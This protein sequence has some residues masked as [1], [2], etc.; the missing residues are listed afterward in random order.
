MKTLSEFL[1]V[2][3]GVEFKI[4]GHPNEIFVIQ[5]NKLWGIDGKY[6]CLL[7]NNPL[8]GIVGKKIIIISQPILTDDERE[9]LKA[10]IDLFKNKKGIYVVKDKEKIYIRNYENDMNE[11]LLC[12]YAPLYL[13]FEKLSENYKYYLKDL[14]LEE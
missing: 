4:E 9:F 10:I 11:L 1:E 13:R 14:G 2:E 3:E 12:V 6:M 8:N 5:A 7:E